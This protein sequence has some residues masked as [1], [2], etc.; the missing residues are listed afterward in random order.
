MNVVKHPTWNTDGQ[1]CQPTD[2]LV[3]DSTRDVNNNARVQFDF[4]LIQDHRPLAVNYVVKLVS[5][6]MI[7]QLR[8]LDFDMVHLGGGPIGRMA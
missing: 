2:G 6:L 8:I 1:H 5:A 3:L 4:V 7:V